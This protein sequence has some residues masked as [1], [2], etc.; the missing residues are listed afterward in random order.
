MN[1]KE[2][3]TRSAWIAEE[4]D[5]LH[6]EL[7]SHVLCQTQ[8]HLAHRLRS[9]RASLGIWSTYPQNL[10]SWAVFRTQLGILDRHQHA[11]HS[12]VPSQCKYL[13]ALKN[14]STMYNQCHCVKQAAFTYY[15][16]LQCSAQGLKKYE[17][18]I[19][20]WLVWL[21][22]KQEQLVQAQCL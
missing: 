5:L 7:V 22:L 9:I 3:I 14:H 16:A 12:S 10:P 2:A 20:S 1:G 17:N 8:S 4:L 13:S 6:G 18:N 11:K 21:N 15:S 19:N